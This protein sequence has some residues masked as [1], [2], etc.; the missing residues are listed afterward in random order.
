M[1]RCRQAIASPTDALPLDIL[2]IISGLLLLAYFLRTLF[3][4]PDFSAPGGLIDHQLSMEMFW[5]TRMGLFQSWMNAEIFQAIFVLACLCSVCLIVGFQVR[6]SAAILYLI[7]VSTYRWN[8]L[9]IYVDDAIIHLLL[10]WMLVLPVGRTLILADWLKNGRG[11]W[12]K[13][14]TIT[15][16]GTV[17][18][19]FLWNLALLYLVAGLW[20]WTSPMWRDGVALYVVFKLPIS[21][22]HDFWKPEHLPL[23]KILNYATLIL[24]PLIPLMLFLPKG[25]YAKY[26]LLA[27]FI[28]LHLGSVATLNIPFANLACTG[29]VIVIFREELMDW[30][31]VGGDGRAAA[32]EIPPHIGLSGGFA[33]FMVAMLTL[34]MLSSVVLPQWRTPLRE[35]FEAQIQ[36]ATNLPADR[37]ARAAGLPGEPQ[38]TRYEGLG[39]VQ[40]TFFGVLW[41]MGIA[42]QYQ[43]FNWIDDRNFTVHYKIDEHRNDGS[44][45]PIEPDTMFPPSLRGVLLQFYIHDI[46]WLRIPPEHREELR[47]SLLTGIA[48]RYCRYHQPTGNIAVYSSVERIDP[49]FDTETGKAEAFLMSFGCRRA[50]P[51]ADEL[52]IAP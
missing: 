6:L 32:T 44:V 43:L 4:A 35:S 28:G 38:E 13:W 22:A 21:Y 16:S 8:F 25:H 51:F 46:T 30:L 1:Y 5:F 11:V 15:V 41:T 23:L 34:A 50:E 29:A 10:F 31:R 48:R 24:E 18:R 52:M 20:K 45:R 9:V 47:Q 36:S 14:K 37:Q 49:R 27:G 40:K 42:Q 39:P 26:A 2:R 17:V 12:G 7:A 19:C 3:E 33:I